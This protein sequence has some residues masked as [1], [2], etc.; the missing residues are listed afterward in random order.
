MKQIFI[1]FFS[2]C[3]CAQKHKINFETNVLS[4][5][6]LSC[7]AIY[8]DTDKVWLGMDKGRY[9]YYDKKTDSLYIHTIAS[10]H[11]TTEFRSIAATKSAVFILAVGNPAK[12]IKI[13]KATLQEQLVYLEEHEKVFYDSMQFVDELNGFAMGDPTADCLSFIS[14]SDGGLS[15]QKV[16]CEN[17]PKVM[18]GEAAFAT[19][20]TNLIIRRK[21]IF[22][23]SGGKQS[24][25]FVSTD[26]G[27]SWKVYPAPIVQGEEMTGIFTAD[28]YNEKIGVIAGGNYLK[29][30]QNWANKAVTKD[31]GKTWNCI[32]DSS[33]FGYA[34]CVQFVPH[35]KG[36]K[37]VSVGGTGVYYSEDFGKNWIHL[38]EEKDLYTF[39]FETEKVGYAT[40]KNKLIRFELK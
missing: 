38:S 32:A 28:F 34:S 31:G 33:A 20:N 35:S 6:H 21:S 29:Q 37:I 22:M 9:G 7:R 30:S 13:D 23:V 40:G 18:E 24:R 10:V 36:K 3:A 5:T 12:L 11:P 27:N 16:S 19:S 17:L 39:R 1:A 2:I 14:T 8:V 4:A 25:V 15:W 26:F